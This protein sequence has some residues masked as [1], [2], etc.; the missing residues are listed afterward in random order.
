MRNFIYNLTGDCIIFRT[1]NSLKF[2]LRTKCC[3]SFTHHVGENLLYKWRSEENSQ[4]KSEELS[5]NT[6]IEH[7]RKQLK[8]A[9]TEG[10]I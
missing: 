9:V 1:Q 4:A 8:Q 2:V 7:L 6:E 10:D 5:I 3:Q